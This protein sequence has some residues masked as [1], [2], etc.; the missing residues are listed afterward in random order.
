MKVYQVSELVAAINA[1]L[2]GFGEVWVRG[3]LS[4]LKVSSSG[5]RYFTLK[6]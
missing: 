5:H 1:Q 2:A 4:G 3:E 6:D